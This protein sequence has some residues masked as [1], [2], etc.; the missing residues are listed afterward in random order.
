[1]KNEQ[2]HFGTDPGIPFNSF[3]N[4]EG[5]TA[6]KTL[7][8]LILFILSFGLSTQLFAAKVIDVDALTHEEIVEISNQLAPHFKFIK[9]RV[10]AQG[11]VQIKSY[12]EDLNAINHLA[13][14][15]ILESAMTIWKRLQFEVFR[16]EPSKQ[17]RELRERSVVMLNEML[18]DK[19]E[20]FVKEIGESVELLSK[21]NYKNDSD[22]ALTS[23]NV[24]MLKELQRLILLKNGQAPLP[25]MDELVNGLKLN[26]VVVAQQLEKFSSILKR[27]I[28]GQPEVVEAL[29]A[30]EWERQFMTSNEVKPDIIYLMGSPGTGKDTAAEALA[31]ALHGK[32]GAYHEHLYRLPIMKR[33]ADM[34]QVLGSA[35]GYVGSDNFPPFLK[36]LIEHSGGRY[37]LDGSNAV[38]ENPD[39]KGQD[40]PGF[41]APS[42][43]VVFINEFH[44]WSKEIKDVFVKQALEKGIFEINNPRGGLTQIEVPVRFV[45]ASN[46][47]ISLTTARETNGQ[48]YGKPLSYEETLKKWEEVSID[49][50]RLKNEIMATNGSVNSGRISIE[51]ISEE[52]LSRIPD[53][54]LLLMRPLSPTDL[55]KI[56]EIDLKKQLKKLENK[57]ALNPGIKVSWGEEVTQIIQG[58]DY[59][60]EDNARPVLG[61]VKSLVV[62]PLVGLLKSG[63]LDLDKPL[64]LLI[65]IDKN[66]D[67]TL[68]LQ[69]QAYADKD[70]LGMFTLPIKFTEKDKTKEAIDDVQI[71]RLAR[72]HEMI[73][74]RV[75]GVD[76]IADRI[77]ER[78]LS[79]A[80]QTTSSQGEPRSASTLVLMGPSSTGKT[81]L[82]KAI[83]EAL[84]GDEKNALVLDFSQ[85]QSVH[86]FKTRVLGSRNAH[87]DPLP[88]D[89]M[90]H[91]DRNNGSLVVVFDELSNVKDPDLLKSLYDFFREPVLSTF[92]DGKER[93]M[94]QVKVIV[95]GNSGI[96]LYKN[97]PRS[98]SMEQQMVAWEEVSKGLLRNR[99]MQRMVLEKSFPEPL[100]TRWGKNNI[101]FVPPHTYKS[102]KQLTQLKLSK[103][104]KKMKA[105]S[106]R[107]GWD[108]GFAGEQDYTLFVE[109]LVEKAFNLRE[110]GA[111]ID[112]FIKDDLMA[113]LES[114]FLSAKI[115]S[116][117]RILIQSLGDGKFGIYSEDTHLAFEMALKKK[118][119]SEA[120][121]RLDEAEDKKFKQVLTAYHEVGH[122][123]AGELLF[124]GQSV[125]T[126]ISILPGVAYINNEWIPYLGIAKAIADSDP[127]ITREWI[128][129]KI[130]VLAAGETAERLVTKGE[131]HS[132]GKSNDMERATRIAE[133]AVIKLG[134]S[135][136]WGTG[137]VPAGTELNTYISRLSDE[138]KKLFETE[139]N[140][141]INEGRAL[142][143][144]LLVSNFESVVIPMSKELARKGV[145]KINDMAPFFEEAK[146]VSVK[147]KKESA[148]SFSLKSWM[149]SLLSP[150][151]PRSE[152]RDGVFKKE[153][154]LPETFAD[155]DE[156]VEQ[157]R[158][159]L[160][161]Q[162]QVPEGVPIFKDFKVKKSA[163]SA[164]CEKFLGLRAGN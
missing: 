109:A 11:E 33:D 134:L 35:T 121:R 75:F 72:L 49:K 110:Q 133:M 83:T 24:K 12:E 89:F 144:E 124:K 148:Q 131:V 16:V 117:S 60:P 143:R 63:D 105:E 25:S 74:K 18:T 29:E 94:T 31:D 73:K 142:A 67:Q 127:N 158:K 38:R 99:E 22:K 17:S 116:G 37:L 59:N 82:S 71:D 145:L 147:E 47:G 27:K 76:A 155:I 42:S 77:S 32:D 64:N 97:I 13:E 1:M 7:K 161:A 50:K 80:N 14:Y 43:A 36:F 157:K 66:E 91:Y 152:L 30:L 90:K 53:R 46:E 114:K 151:V 2:R 130:A 5:R 52:L 10:E 86:D 136:A 9:T 132:A 3:G 112:S 48:R 106:G 123:L 100:I 95:T 54:F 45:V 140:K 21:A 92:S 69:V 139:V 93:V 129:R 15:S 61:R 104:I 62:E 39:W 159:D 107:R 65:S 58:Y 6:L 96:E 108:L 128:V 120:E 150:G 8:T 41:P 98:V 28:I 70:D 156:I 126:E 118:A 85:I 34:W 78:V 51:G 87:G 119:P 135:D 164:D 149:R 162:V 160:F 44:N 146:L 20:I 153:D 19:D 125:Q 113:P 68:S 88:S 122:A 81:E 102:L 40:L 163:F 57:T 84:T 101:F 56:A 103:M 138:R 55:Q 154:L 23:L 141:L 111:S 115:P 79:L 4:E 26:K 137:A